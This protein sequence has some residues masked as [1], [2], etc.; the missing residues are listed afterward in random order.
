MVSREK[1]NLV[2]HED[3]IFQTIATHERK[4]LNLKKSPLLRSSQSHPKE[5]LV[6]TSDNRIISIKNRKI[7]LTTKSEHPIC[8][9]TNLRFKDYNIN[10]VAHIEELYCLHCPEQSNLKNHKIEHVPDQRM[11]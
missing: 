5:R 3:F 4:Q 6:K 2:A 10:G 9:T 1:S 7:T 11:D 8:L